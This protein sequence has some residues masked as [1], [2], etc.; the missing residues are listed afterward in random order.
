MKTNIGLFLKKRAE[1]C[2]D[3]EAIVEF[4]RERSFTFAELNAR[5]NRVANA[6]LEADVGPGD[7]VATLLKNGV[8]FVETYFGAAKIGAV[9]V[10]L[11]WR[12]VA[13]ELDYILG[14][15]GAK[16][17][18][19][20]SD[21]DETVNALHAGQENLA[22]ELWLRRENAEAGAP[23]WATDYEQFMANASADEPPVG[24]WDDDNLFIMYTSGTT[25][26]PKGAVHSHDGMLWSQLTSMSTSDMRDGDR[27]LLAMP[28]F[29][30]GTLS[31]ASLLVHRG[32]TGVIM[33]ELDIAAMFHCIEQQKVTIFMAVPALLQFM[34]AVPEMQQ[35]DTSAVRWI[36]TGA[37][38]VPVSLLHEYETRGVRICQ[39]YG[40]TESCGP[41]TLLLPEDAENRVGSCG[42]P[43]MHTEIKIVDGHGNTIPMGS[44]EP[45]ELLITGRHMM[46]GYWNNPEA[47]A[48]TLRDG[49]LYT[50][51]ICTWDADGFVT[52]CDRKKDMIISGGENIYP[53]ELENVLAAC[54]EVQDVAVIGVPSEKWGETPLALVVPAPD[55]SP[56]PDSL[57]AYC[58][59][60]LAGYKVPQLY[61]LVDSL[62][63]NP[64]GKLLKPELREK[65]PGPAPF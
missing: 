42:R 14:D 12:L 46:K 33:R 3:R 52:V 28:M 49:W 4:E 45:G 29:H 58:K 8:E 53:A 9:F 59:D 54:P 2:P 1:I 56:T 51:D 18:V 64:S 38:P 61:E 41:G 30:V 39:A 5:A 21:F 24:A 6:L 48:A 62:P 20:D 13:A 63:R 36:A 17:L 47:T 10:P 37:A 22:V 43:Q 26:R 55:A 31:P 23:D 16:A 15:C 60:N 57:K 32:G 35:C 7:R 19:Y 65:F 50:G 11:N 40:L 34:L 44:D 27:W 25:G